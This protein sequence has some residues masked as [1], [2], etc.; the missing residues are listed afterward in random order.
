LSRKAFSEPGDYAQNRRAAKAGLWL[1]LSAVVLATCST[2]PRRLRTWTDVFDIRDTVALSASF[3]RLLEADTVRYGTRGQISRWYLAEPA[4]PYVS[5]SALRVGRLEPFPGERDQRAILSGLAPF[6]QRLGASLLR[7]PRI[8]EEVPYW[9]SLPYSQVAAQ[10]GGRIFVASNLFYPIFL[11]DH[12][13]RLVDSLVTPPSWRGIRRTERGEFPDDPRGDSAFARFL[14]SFSMIVDMAVVADS[15][16]VV[17]HG[18]YRRGDD[19]ILRI[20]AMFSD[21][22]VNGTRVATDLPS[23]GRILAYSHGSIFFLSGPPE[24]RWRLIEHRWR[25][26]AR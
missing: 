1:A 18:Q 6:S 13:Q 17:N 23:P 16:L 5:V 12:E 24:S 15:V 9:V 19:D 7:K 2:E 11:F 25:G 14:E 3:A 10:G 4:S 20:G 21:V 22:Y 26:G 8:V